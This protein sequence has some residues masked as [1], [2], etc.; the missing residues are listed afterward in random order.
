MIINL[1]N[2]N[3]HQIQLQ[4][5]GQKS[6]ELDD[7]IIPPSLFEILRRLALV[8]IPYCPKTVT[9]SK[10]FIT[11]FDALTESLYDTRIK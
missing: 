3:Y 2:Y 5:W 9:S 4:D 8:E 10:Q 6:N 11:K 1:I 7:F